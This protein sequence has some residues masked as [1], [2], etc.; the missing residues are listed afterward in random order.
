MFPLSNATVVTVEAAVSDLGV[1]GAYNQEYCQPL[2][3]PYP[4]TVT[5]KNPAPGFRTCQGAIYIDRL[6]GI[7]VT[8]Q[9]LPGWV[10]VQEDMGIRNVVGTVGV[11]PVGGSTFNGVL[12]EMTDVAVVFY[13]LYIEPFRRG[14]AYG[15]RRVA[16][17]E[18]CGIR[19]GEFQSFIPT[20][21]P[22]FRRTPYRLVWPGCRY[23]V[24]GTVSALYDV[25]LGQLFNSV[26]PFTATGE[27]LDFQ[28]SAELDYVVARVGTTTP[29]SNLM[30][31]TI[32]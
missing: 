8:G 14:L 2:A 30:V 16:V 27:Y 32:S 5:N 23:P 10:W 11:A 6:F 17:L 13:V 26:M 22:D 1:L 4:G 3:Y 25:T 19:S 28:E 20:D 31:S 9:S 12:Y 29:G 21:I 15:D 24:I 18:Q 7:L